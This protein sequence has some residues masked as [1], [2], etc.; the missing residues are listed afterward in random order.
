MAYY[1]F[2]VNCFN[3][4]YWHFHKQADKDNT[5]FASEKLGHLFIDFTSS[6]VFDS[7]A[8]PT[9]LTIPGTQLCKNSVL[10][11]HALYQFVFNALT[12]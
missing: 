1:R 11:K 10:H 12:F 6:V 4:V 9:E 2:V 3:T 7:A 5:K 8:T